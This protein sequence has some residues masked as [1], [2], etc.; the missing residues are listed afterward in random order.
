M[1]KGTEKEVKDLLQDLFGY[2]DEIVLQGEGSSLEE[3]YKNSI[4]NILKKM[5][6]TN[7]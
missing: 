3:V 7:G 1:D 2:F 5:E 4:E 6:E